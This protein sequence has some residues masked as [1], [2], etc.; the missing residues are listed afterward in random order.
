M[1]V[2]SRFLR[3]MRRLCDGYL[4]VIKGLCDY[5]LTIS[6]FLFLQHQIR[7]MVMVMH[8]GYIGYISVIFL[9]TPI[10]LTGGDGDL[11]R[12]I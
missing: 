3:A 1:T 10:R 6:G 9:R 8:I 7:Q 5:S 11:R 4:K 12:I 2:L